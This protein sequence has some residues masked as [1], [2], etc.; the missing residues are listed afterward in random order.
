MSQV[1][2]LVDQKN[3]Q[4]SQL[5]ELTTIVLQM[6]EL[7]YIL[8]QVD[9]QSPQVA[10][11][12][13]QQYN[14]P[15]F[16][17]I[18]F[19][20]LTEKS[21]MNFDFLQKCVYILKD[22]TKV[23]IRN[24]SP[25]YLAFHFN[26]L[27]H[28]I[29]SNHS[30]L[31]SLSF[32]FIDTASS[33][34]SSHIYEVHYNDFFDHISFT[35]PLLTSLINIFEF[36]SR[37]YKKSLNCDP[38]EPISFLA[39]YNQKIFPILGNHQI[40]Q[41]TEGIDVVRKILIIFK[42]TFFRTNLPIEEAKNMIQYIQTIQ[43]AYIN[44]AFQN[45]QL[46]KTTISVMKE[47]YMKKKLY[48]TF[49]EN[50]SNILLTHFQMLSC[51]L[52]PEMIF[53]SS[54]L[55]SILKII[56]IYSKYI[57][58]QQE[59]VN[60]LLTASKLTQSD[61][62]NFTQNPNIYYYDIYDTTAVEA[63]MA[64]RIA[65]SL[66]SNIVSEQPQLLLY[67]MSLQ[68]DEHIV[69][70]ISFCVKVLF[71]EHNQLPEQLMS[72]YMNLLNMIHESMNSNGNRNTNLLFVTAV[73]D[74]IRYMVPSLPIEHNSKLM[75]ILP[76]FFKSEN[77]II[78]IFAC[79]LF[80][81]LIK[82]DIFPFDGAIHVLV[83]FLPRCFTSH[84]FKSIQLMMKIQKEIVLPYSDSVLEALF[85]SFDMAFE[86]VNTD[87]LDQAER[88][89]DTIS[90]NLDFCTMLIES[91]GAYLIKPYF[92]TVIKNIFENEVTDCADNLCNMLSATFLTGSQLIPQFI[93]IIMEYLNNDS[94]WDGFIY[95]LFD[96]FFALLSSFPE[97]FIQLNISSVLIE[98]CIHQIVNPKSKDLDTILKLGSFITWLILIDDRIDI[99]PIVQCGNALFNTE[100]VDFR[101]IFSF[102]NIFAAISL[103]RKVFF[104]QSI[105]QKMYEAAN[106]NYFLL[107][108]QKKLFIRFFLALVDHDHSSAE[109]FVPLIFH[110]LNEE[111]LQML[112]TDGEYLFD[113]SYPNELSALVNEKEFESPLVK[114]S[115]IE[116]IITALQ[117]LQQSTIQK[118]QTQYPEVFA[119][120]TQQQQQH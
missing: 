15:N 55:S 117:L 32:V 101:F 28:L 53:D 107:I 80:K 16:G 44:K 91:T 6:E 82:N 120:Y 43:Q 45:T 92:L 52:D 5:F 83:H 72:Y 106:R 50:A 58:V 60:I 3:S 95:S 105:I 47:F 13:Q 49:Q 104:D 85:E 93:Q 68:P 8:T 42:N 108:W 62:D 100:N 94:A 27:K 10:Q 98:F 67:L 69:R 26:T 18:L 110:L 34:K 88:S 9:D 21:D 2:I 74:L 109:T 96:P 59:T 112:G 70:C 63:M 65:R 20:A 19:S 54:L 17:S 51:A 25:E 4:S 66:I 41:E 29:L 75:E 76:S 84:V 61:I 46:V 56:E 37:K 116:M 39:Q 97:A 11:Y 71:A 99:E 48:L 7:I 36:A 111:R 113:Q 73:L 119:Q 22:W 1:K 12:I 103:T 86:N 114:F 115:F 57:P 78:C 14:N 38:S 89:I 24:L 30:Q 102:L 31:V 77:E 118:I 35:F 33:I 79:R 90:H 23:N 87:D 40:L 81:K 64:P